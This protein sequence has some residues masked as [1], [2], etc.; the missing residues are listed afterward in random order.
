MPKFGFIAFLCHFIMIF[1][2]NARFLLLKGGGGTGAQGWV[3]PPLPPLCPCM[4]APIRVHMNH[5]QR[6]YFVRSSV[7]RQ[8]NIVLFVRTWKW[9]DC[10]SLGIKVIQNQISLILTM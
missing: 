6:D 3:Y 7:T 5:T 2:Q 9:R 1:G 4:T 8:R 10:S